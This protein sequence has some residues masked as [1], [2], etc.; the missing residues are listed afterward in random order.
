M[1]ILTMSAAALL[2]SALGAT[3]A[4]AV[5]PTACDDDHNGYV[6]GSEAKSCTEQRFQEIVAGQ[7][8]L[9]PE[10]FSKAFPN[11]QNAS[12]LFKEADQNGDGQISREEWSQWQEQSFATATA[13]SGNQMPVPDYQ[14]WAG[15]TWTR[16]VQ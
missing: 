4:S 12:Q 14:K 6:S 5:V 16:P 8:G 13:K 3:T 11:A 1:R 2:L 10:Q 7:K 9:G 15:G